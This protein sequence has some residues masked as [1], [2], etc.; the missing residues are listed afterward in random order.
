MLLSA[1][2]PRELTECWYAGCKLAALLACGLGSCTVS[3]LF[4]D[5][6]VL[7]ACA[8]VDGP[9]ALCWAPEGS[10]TSAGTS[11]ATSCDRS[12]TRPQGGQPSLECC[13]RVL[14]LCFAW[15]ST[16]SAFAA[17]QM[18]H[19]L[20]FDAETYG[21]CYALKVS[22]HS[23]QDSRQHAQVSTALCRLRHA[24]ICT[25]CRNLPEQST[26]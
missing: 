11:H 15:F 22:A 10:P 17:L 5:V 6:C 8:A 16:N 1:P 19:D 14:L 25:A 20:K 4:N 12:Q 9:K 21:M 3:V 26:V 24:H 13:T 2:V 18:T 7:K 23:M